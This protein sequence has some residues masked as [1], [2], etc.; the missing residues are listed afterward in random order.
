VGTGSASSASNSVTPATTADAPTIG[1]ATRGN[2][3]ATLTWTAPAGDGGSSI[4]GYAVT[5]YIG[6][7]PQ[8]PQTFNST[9]T[10]AT[11]T[12]LTNGTAYTFTVAAINGVGTGTAS[13]ASNSVTPATV[14]GVPT[15]IHVTAGKGSVKV[16]WTAPSSNGGSVITHYVITP[17][18]GPAVTVGPV[19]SDTVTGLTNGKAYT[20]T[21]KATNSVGTGAASARSSSVTPNGLYIVTTTLPAATKGKKYSAVVLKEKNGVGT[22]TWSA[23]GLPK[24]LTLSSAGV[25]SG[26][27]SSSDAVKTYAVTVTVKDS[28]TPTKQTATSKL[29]LVVG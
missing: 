13:S 18:S 14:P 24:G 10:T 11:V 2:A 5:P 7:T 20:F 9:A 12:G 15:G 4:T 29:S 8:A 19:T 21:V 17:S 22:E 28:S 26:T 25:L 27:V 3:S 1:T 23:T 6:A 16:T